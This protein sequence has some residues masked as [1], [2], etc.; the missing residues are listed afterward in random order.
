MPHAPD[1]GTPEAKAAER[2]EEASGGD[3]VMQAKATLNRARTLDQEGNSTGCF[4][5]LAE[6]KRQ[7][8]Q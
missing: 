4:E 1:H 2:A 5:A 6:A 7:L 3:R 8:E